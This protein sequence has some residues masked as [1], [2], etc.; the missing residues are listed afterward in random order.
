M[1]GMQALPENKRCIEEGRMIKK[2]SGTAVEGEMIIEQAGS[3]P[4]AL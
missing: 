3:Y 2:L 1:N 4:L